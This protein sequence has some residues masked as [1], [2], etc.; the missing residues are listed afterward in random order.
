MPDRVNESLLDV[1]TLQRN[2][3]SGR[4][5]EEQAQAFLASLEDCE[6]EAAWTTTAMNMPANAVFTE[7]APQDD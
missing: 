6:A 2:L 1:R 7:P 3:G 4:I 5:T